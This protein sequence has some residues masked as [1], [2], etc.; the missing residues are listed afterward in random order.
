MAFAL[1]FLS[2]NPLAA[3]D[4]C[5]RA[6][7][8]V[9]M[10]GMEQAIRAYVSEKSGNGGMSLIKDTVLNKTWSLSLVRVHKDRL[11]KLDSEK[12][13]QCA[14]FVARDGTKVDIDFFLK[15][16]AGRLLVSD[17]KVHKINNKARYDYQFKDG[18][19]I[20]V[21]ENQLTQRSRD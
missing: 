3:G 12:Y 5:A 15:I 13:F 14:D 2:V 8:A 17:S 21:E 19:W 16:D 7:Q 4:C 11:A 10:D 9:T 6:G 18:Y 20:P 1:L